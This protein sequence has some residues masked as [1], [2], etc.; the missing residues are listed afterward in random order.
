MGDGR[1]RTQF[2]MCAVS[3]IQ[4]NGR[5]R[6]MY[7]R[8]VSKGK[9]VKVALV[10]VACK[11]LKTAYALVTKKQMYNANFL[12]FAPWILLQFVLRRVAPK[13]LDPQKK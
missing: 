2:Y 11:L 7:E 12:Q 5:C 8:M 3:A 1:L 4:S 9:P 13:D 6:A 10:A